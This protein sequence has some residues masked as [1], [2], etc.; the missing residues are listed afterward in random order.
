MSWNEM[1]ILRLLI[2][3]PGGLFG[4]D[5][6]ALSNGRLRR[7]SIYT[8]LARMVR[9]GYIKESHERPEAPHLTPRTRHHVSAAGY[10]AYKERL[11]AHGLIELRSTFS[12]TGA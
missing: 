1:L 4:S 7:G 3:N 10:R 6:L 5:F 9:K 12:G 8:M 11:E 2:D